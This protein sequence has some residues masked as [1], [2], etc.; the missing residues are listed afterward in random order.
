MFTPN[1]GILAT[2]TKGYSRYL[3]EGE[4]KNL[5][6]KDVQNQGLQGGI[7]KFWHIFG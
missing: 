3:G 4:M 1:P 2:H 7:K 5:R 6:Q